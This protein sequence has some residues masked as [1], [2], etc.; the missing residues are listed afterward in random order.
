MGKVSFSKVVSSGDGGSWEDVEKLGTF[1][2][3]LNAK[4]VLNFGAKNLRDNTKRVVVFISIKGKEGL[5]QVSCSKELS[6]MVRK[7]LAG[8][9]EKISVLR[10]LLNLQVIENDQGK[11]IS[12]DGK[13]PEGLSLDSILEEDVVAVEFESLI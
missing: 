10:G 1:R 3:C 13:L 4:S 9:K 8:G 6:T 7:A 11:F 2:E 12:L 5:E